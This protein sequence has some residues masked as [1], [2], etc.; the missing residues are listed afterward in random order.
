MHRIRERYGGNDK[1]KP[2]GAIEQN[3]IEESVWGQSQIDYKLGLSRGTGLKKNGI[4]SESRVEKQGIW[5]LLGI[6]TT[7]PRTKATGKCIYGDKLLG[8]SVRNSATISHVGQ[9]TI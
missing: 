9:I 2:V 1:K 6:F 7:D 5:G 3:R 8:C 4:I